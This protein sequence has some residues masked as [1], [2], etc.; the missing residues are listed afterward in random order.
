MTFKARIQSEGKI[1][2][3][4]RDNSLSTTSFYDCYVKKFEG[5]EVRFTP[6]G[7]IF[8]VIASMTRRLSYLFLHHKCGISVLNMQDGCTCKSPRNDLFLCKT[9]E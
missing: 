4:Y 9:S 2:H 1:L 5:A 6:F 7:A 8:L 3:Q